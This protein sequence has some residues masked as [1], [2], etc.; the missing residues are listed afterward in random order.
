M[1]ASKVKICLFA[2]FNNSFTSFNIEGKNEEEI[3]ESMIWYLLQFYDSCFNFIFC[4]NTLKVINL[5]NFESFQADLFLVVGVSYA[6]ISNNQL[7]NCN[8][9]NLGTIFNYG[10]NIRGF[11]YQGDDISYPNLDQFIQFE[12]NIFTQLT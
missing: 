1:W 7:I 12:N 8:Y 3:S 2:L 4:N 9:I 11:S 10:V 5:T 6:N